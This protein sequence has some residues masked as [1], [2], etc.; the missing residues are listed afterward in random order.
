MSGFHTVTEDGGPGSSIHRAADDQTTTAQDD[1]ITFKDAEV[2]INEDG[3]DLDFRVEGDTET[4][5]LICDASTDRVGIGTATPDSL[6]EVSEAAADAEVTI[7]CYHDTEATTPKITLRKADGSEASPALVDDNAVLGTI[8]FQGH[9]GSGFEQGAKIEARIQGDVDSPSDGSDMPTELTFWTTPDG[10]A[11]AVER[12]N[13]DQAGRV[14][15]GTHEIAQNAAGL[16]IFKDLGATSDLSAYSDYHLVLKGGG[17]TDDYAAMLFSSSTSVN[18]GSAIV[19][20]DTGGAGKGELAFLTQQGTGGAAP[21]EVMRLDDAG[22]VGISETTPSKMLDL[23]NGASGGDILAYD[24][25]THDGGVTSSDERMKENITSS[26]LGLDFINSLNP[27]S[28]KWKDT[29]EVI[30]KVPVAAR[31]AVYETVEASP[32]IEAGEGVEAKEAVYEERLVSEAVEAGERIANVYPATAYTR[33]HYGLIAQEVKQTLSDAGLGN[34]DF[35]GYCYEEDRDQHAL[36]YNEFISP[37][38]KAVQELTA[39]VEALEN[40]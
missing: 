40:K 37:L 25:Y 1:Q 15:I 29:E 28:Y 17:A 7:S 8:S 31:D 27:V 24:V 33:T 22:N 12:M 9:D 2:V 34:D 35:A 18:G 30:D 5:L 36:R 19:H 11:T 38:I 3:D 32:A 6:L 23:K 26:A 13:I 21:V 16:E 39:K 14:G 4:N 10:S 20:Y